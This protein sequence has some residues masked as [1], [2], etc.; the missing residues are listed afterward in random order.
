MW[1]F[2]WFKVKFGGLGSS[3]GFSGKAKTTGKVKCAMPACE[4]MRI[5]S[6]AL[7]MA[8]LAVALATPALTNALSQPAALGMPP[9]V[10]AYADDYPAPNRPAAPPTIHLAAAPREVQPTPGATVDARPASTIRVEHAPVPQ[11]IDADGRA[12]APAKCNQGAASIA[13]VPDL[14]FCCPKTLAPY[15]SE[16]GSTGIG[17]DRYDYTGCPFR[18]YDSAGAALNA[19]GVQK[20]YHFGNPQITV[21]RNNEAEVAFCSLHSESAN[22][23]TPRS[24]ASGSSQTTFTSADQGITWAD[25]P[26]NDTPGL[27]ESASCTMDSDGNIY[28]GYLYSQDNGNATSGYGSTIW[29]VK[30]GTAH[31]PGSVGQ[32][33]AGGV[34]IHGRT[35]LNPIPSLNVIDVPAYIAPPPVYTNDTYGPPANESEVG[36]QAVPQPNAGDE[37]VGA[38]W[39]ER[40]TEYVRHVEGA[41]VCKSSNGMPGWIDAAFTTIGASDNWT[42][43]TD[44]QLIGPCMD[45]SNPVQFDG[46]V[47][48]ACE[49]EK[50]YDARSRAKIGDIDIWRINP[51]TGNTTI[52]SSTYVVGGHPLLATTSTGYMV[53]VTTKYTGPTTGAAIFAAFGWYGRG[54]NPTGVNLGPQLHRMA[55]SH[56]MRDAGVTAL[57]ISETEKTSILEYMEWDNLG[58]KTDVPDPPMID[59]NNPG[60]PTPPAIKDFQKSFVTFNSCNFPLAAA[61][62]ETGTGVSADNAD[63]YGQNPAIFDDNQD[64]IQSYTEAGGSD[65]FYFA[66]NDYGAMQYGTVLTAAASSLCPV[67]PPLPPAPPLPIPQALTLGNPALTGV[68]AVVGATAVAGVLYLVT[69][70]RRTM[71]LAVAEAK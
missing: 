3:H 70:K 31:D 29:L 63:A 57:A 23:P 5:R 10:G 21:N 22:G 32:A 67:P 59:P 45:A 62:L 19:N 15:G 38:V 56:R 33:Y 36:N 49:V 68:G 52:V 27:G 47:Y 53:M 50:G 34:E 71:N 20:D 24:R 26:P 8:I 69:A 65:L 18:I 25:Q 40:C 16:S 12:T 35:G 42:R 17:A 41:Q 61:R 58:N 4:A 37:R 44:K 39:F 60:V 30:A 43:L 11:L 51:M 55:G 64:G 54:W 48:V 13:N 6:S 9:A 14:Q 2:S 66:V 7:A 28:V 1:L 46:E